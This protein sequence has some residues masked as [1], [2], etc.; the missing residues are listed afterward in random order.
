MEYNKLNQIKIK[1]LVE[2]HECKSR[3]SVDQRFFLKER[4]DPTK[5]LSLVLDEHTAAPRLKFNIHHETKSLKLNSSSTER[6]TRL[7]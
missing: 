2:N 7:A 6:L 1:Q 3:V 5:A 4:F